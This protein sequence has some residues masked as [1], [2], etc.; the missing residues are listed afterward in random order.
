MRNHPAD[1][2]D[3]R[4]MSVFGSDDKEGVGNG[5]SRRSGAF[6]G[7]KSFGPNRSFGMGNPG[8]SE[9]L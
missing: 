9:N 7:R 1:A 8:K 3:G 5:F 4:K 2:E 6:N